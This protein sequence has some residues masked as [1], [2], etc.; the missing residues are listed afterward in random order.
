MWSIP[1]PGVKRSL[2][3]A[4]SSGKRSGKGGSSAPG[5]TGG[6]IRNKEQPR[7]LAKLPSPPPSK[8]KQGKP[9][10]G[11]TDAASPKFS[12]TFGPRTLSSSHLHH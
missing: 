2:G 12:A 7:H 4:V 3:E 11:G 5:G 6:L 9:G 1:S 8:Q 10:A